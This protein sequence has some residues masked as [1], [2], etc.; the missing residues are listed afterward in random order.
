[1]SVQAAAAAPPLATLDDPEGAGD[2]GPDAPPPPADPNDAPQLRPPNGQL[3]DP[4]RQGKGGTD[5]HAVTRPYSPRRRFALTAAPMFAS[6]RSPF[7]ARPERF[8]AGGGVAVEMDVRIVRWLWLR[9]IG[10][11]SAHPVGER[12]QITEEGEPPIVVAN[13]GVLQ[14]GHAGL[15][16]VYPLDLGRIL[17]QLDVGAGVLWVKSPDAAVTGQLGAPCREGNVC[18]FGL[19]C[20][21]DATCQIAPQ[22]EIH[23]GLA[24][25]VLIGQRWSVGAHFRYFALL[26]G[27]SD[28]NSSFPA[29]LQIAARLA[30]RF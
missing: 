8:H 15:S 12:K 19:A 30:V 29:Y 23:I 20:S 13:R 21:A 18:D 7:I 9:A 6:F 24:V 27:L 11:Y 22:P 1:M 4:Q 2:A 5:L 26:S 10:S 3:G 17:P 14:A 16:A 28:I 25:D